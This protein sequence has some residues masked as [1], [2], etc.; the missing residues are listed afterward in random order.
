MLNTLSPANASDLSTATMAT[1]MNFPYPILTPIAAAT[2]RPLYT[3]LCVMQLELNA[4]AAAVYTLIGD[5]IS[6][7]VF[8]TITADA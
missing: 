5:G 1:K 6:S 3:T 8:L 7:H 2:I 4:N